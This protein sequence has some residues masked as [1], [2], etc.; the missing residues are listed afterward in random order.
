[1]VR[2]RYPSSVPIGSPATAVPGKIAVRNWLPSAALPIAHT[3]Q[4]VPTMCAASGSESGAIGIP[5]SAPC[6]ADSSD[7]TDTVTTCNRSPSSSFAE[8]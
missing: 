7:R 2:T 6:G 8:E 3:D 1:M 4:S 5:I